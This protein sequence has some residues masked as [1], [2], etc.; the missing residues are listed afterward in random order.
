VSTEPVTTASGLQYIDITPGTGASP[1]LGQTVRVEY[2]G[3]LASDGTTFDSSYR[4]GEPTEFVLGQVIEGWNEGLATMQAGGKRRL[5]IPAALAYG[6]AG[7]GQIPPNADLI[8]D[9][10]LLEVKE[11]LQATP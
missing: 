1:T 7:Q 10:E 4:R 6:E 2:T 8:F 9:I 3:W 5:I 11:T